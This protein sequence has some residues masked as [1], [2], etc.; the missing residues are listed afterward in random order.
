MLHVARC[1]RWQP[2][3]HF[4]NTHS[5]GVFILLHT[6]YN[7]GRSSLGWNLLYAVLENKSC[8]D[9][10]LHRLVEDA[11]ADLHNF[12]ILLLLVARAL[13]VR[14]PAAL[15]LLAGVDE[16]AHRAVLIENLGGRGQV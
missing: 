8:A 1:C 14:H 7:A 15:I 6:S 16:V 9:A 12:Q 10:Y 3:T 11:A 13:D 2:T 5:V 4:N